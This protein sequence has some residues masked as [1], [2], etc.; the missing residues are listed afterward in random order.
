M[1]SKTIANIRLKAIMVDMKKETEIEYINRIR[2]YINLKAICEDYN[3]KASSQIDYNNLRAVLNGV[4]S[5]RVSKERLESFVDYLHKD[6]FINVFQMKTN[7]KPL[8]I[9]EIEGIIKKHVF[10]MHDH[11]IEEL[12]ND[13]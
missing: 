9:N 8:N 10:N 1:L 12:E 3:T 5:T 2:P 6:L 7:S 4:S 11:L 13:F